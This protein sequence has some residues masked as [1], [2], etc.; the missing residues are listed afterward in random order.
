MIIDEGF[1]SNAKKIAETK[2]QQSEV[3]APVIKRENY[4]YHIKITFDDDI[5]YS[6]EKCSKYILSCDIFKEKAN[7]DIDNSKGTLVF[8]ADM[9]I[10]VD[11]VYKFLYC[12]NRYTTLDITGEKEIYIEIFYNDFKIYNIMSIDDDDI[13]IM[14]GDF[15]K[16]GISRNTLIRYIIRNSGIFFIDI[17]DIWETGTKKYDVYPVR[18]NYDDICGIIKPRIHYTSA[19]VYNATELNKILYI[20][21]NKINDEKKKYS[22]IIE[23]LKNYSQCEYIIYTDES[24]IYIHTA[25]LMIYEGVYTY[26]SFKLSLNDPIPDEFNDLQIMMD[27]NIKK[28]LKVNSNDTS[29]IDFIDYG[30]FMEEYKKNMKTMRYSCSIYIDLNCELYKAKMTIF[31]CDLFRKYRIIKTGLDENVY[32]AIMFDAE[33]D[34]TAENVYQFL[35]GITKI[36]FS[37]YMFENSGKITIIDRNTKKKT[38]GTIP[39]YNYNSIKKNYINNILNLFPF[40]GLMYEIMD[41]LNSIY[42][43][44]NKN[45]ILYINMK[46]SPKNLTAALYIENP[47]GISDIMNGKYKTCIVRENTRRLVPYG[48]IT[49][50]Q[51]FGILESEDIHRYMTEFTINENNVRI[52]IYPMYSVLVDNEYSYPCI[53]SEASKDED[54]EQ[55]TYIC[56][57]AEKMR[58]YRMYVEMKVSDIKFGE[59]GNDGSIK[60]KFL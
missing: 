8:D 59:I 4:E 49:D 7:V 5:E 39:S 31:N 30:K 52:R 28:S 41:D 18:I 22:E 34:M 56:E 21:K 37:N 60:R 45:G 1:L 20:D 47:S 33:I 44:E 26:S 43:W 15:E 19:I 6:I 55:Y 35:A 14:Y 36:K 57:L 40:E 10:S 24:Y 27:N 16:F 3:K 48:N 54:S 12:L 58:E 25:H 46:E 11:T 53:V 13:E 17:W 51:L 42:D 38:E 50:G 9:F 23:L 2:P 29:D 32:F